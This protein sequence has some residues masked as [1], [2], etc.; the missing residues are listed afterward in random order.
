MIIRF[1]CRKMTMTN[2]EALYA[3][4]NYGEACCSRQI[5]EQAVCIDGDISGGFPLFMIIRGKYF[6]RTVRWQI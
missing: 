6:E 3:R 4:L 5:E 1:P 2:P